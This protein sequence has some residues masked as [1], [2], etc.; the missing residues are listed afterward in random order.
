MKGTYYFQY[1]IKAKKNQKWLGKLGQ[2]SGRD[3][4]DLGGERE[5]EKGPWVGVG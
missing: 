4:P 3:G 2:A 1:E 5:E